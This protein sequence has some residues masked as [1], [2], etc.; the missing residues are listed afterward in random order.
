MIPT[1]PRPRRRAPTRAD[2]VVLALLSA[3]VPLA[4]RAAALPGDSHLVLVR[5]GSQ[6]PRVVDASHD[7]DVEVVGPL[8]PALVRV[9][10]GEVW[11]ESA[12]C[13]NHLCQRMGR[14]RGPGRSLVCVPNQLLVRFAPAVSGDVDTITR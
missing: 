6:T 3:A 11:I 10:H 7:A 12:P 4:R 8:G 2:L 14:L 13:R 9:R 5:A 1:I